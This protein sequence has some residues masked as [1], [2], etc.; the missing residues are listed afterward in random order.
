MP[1]Y[2]LDTSALA[3]LYHTETGSEYMER[4]LREPGSQSFISRLSILEIESVFAIKLRTREVDQT[5]VEI[6][7]RVFR[8][9]LS[10]GRLLIGPPI[11]THH[12]QTARSLLVRYG[13]AEG[14]RTLDALQLSVALSLQQLGLISVM[15]AADQRLC[16]VASLAGCPTVNPERPSPLLI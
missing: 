12:Y 7:R 13:A 16:Q 9:D 8:A 6:A 5:D 10:Q 4:L 3:K 11:Q 2:F 15:I 14:L 1:N